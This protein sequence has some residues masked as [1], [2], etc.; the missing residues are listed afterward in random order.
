LKPSR[1]PPA[2]A[3]RIVK[4]WTRRRLPRS[5]WSHCPLAPGE[6]HLL[7]RTMLPSTARDASS[8]SEQAGGLSTAL[9]R[10]RLR[11]PREYLL[12]GIAALSASMAED[13]RDASAESNGPA[14]R[15]PS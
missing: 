2:P 1:S 7:S 6:H 3:W 4:R 8:A 14:Q 9:A 10:A 11:P 13:C 12:N 15:R 5:I